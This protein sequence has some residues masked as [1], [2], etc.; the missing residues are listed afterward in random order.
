MRVV[1]PVDK[2]APFLRSRPSSESTSTLRASPPTIAI[3]KNRIQR[4]PMLG[5]V[6]SMRLSLSI[7][8]KTLHPVLNTHVMHAR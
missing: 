4:L 2:P 1:T 7:I 6:A 8:P 5:S 3:T